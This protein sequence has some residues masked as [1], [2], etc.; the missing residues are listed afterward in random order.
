M[1][2]KRDIRHSG[3]RVLEQLLAARDEAKVQLHLLGMDARRAF[4][5]LEPQITALEQRAEQEGEQAMESLKSASQ[6]LTRTIHE[7]M[8]RAAQ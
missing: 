1:S 5:E 4:A 6:E 8:G 2:M 7:L 3:R